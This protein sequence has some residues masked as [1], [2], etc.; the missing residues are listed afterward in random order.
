MG[1][2]VGKF[3]NLNLKINQSLMGKINIIQSQNMLVPFF[4][5]ELIHI[6]ESETHPS[7]TPQK[8]AELKWWKINDCSFVEDFPMED[9]CFTIVISLWNFYTVKKCSSSWTKIKQFWI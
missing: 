4:Y 7:P 3:V 2:N 8:N 5:L 1:R 6:L 9:Y